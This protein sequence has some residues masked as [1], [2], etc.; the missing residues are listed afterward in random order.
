MDRPVSPKASYLVPVA[1]LL[2]LAAVWV[3]FP[4]RLQA[5]FATLK[6]F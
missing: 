2:A 4:A 6:S 5:F 1:L 3:F